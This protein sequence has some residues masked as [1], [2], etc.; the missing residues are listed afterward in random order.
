MNFADGRRIALERRGQGA[1]SPSQEISLKPRKESIL[2]FARRRRAER[3]DEAERA[4]QSPIRREGPS[5]GAEVA[6]EAIRR[7]DE[8]TAFR[9]APKNAL[10]IGLQGGFVIPLFSL[11]EA[12]MQGIGGL[13]SA[14]VESR[15]IVGGMV[16][17]DPAADLDYLLWFAVGV[18]LIWPVY[19]ALRRGWGAKAVGLYGLGAVM[20]LVAGLVL[21]H[22]L[23]IGKGI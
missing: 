8:E 11:V 18:L 10:K 22:Y 15:L 5:L 20:G 13:G 4:A 14:E 12:Q 9:E 3:R 21:L 17:F 16:L 23:G 19:G 1:H 2:S 6:Q 7:H